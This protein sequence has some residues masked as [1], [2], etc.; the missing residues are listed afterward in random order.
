MQLVLER[1]QIEKLRKTY[2]YTNG[3]D[4]QLAQVVL[5]VAE[6]WS[7]SKIAIALKLDPETISAYLREYSNPKKPILRKRLTKYRLTSD[8][9]AELV[10]HIE[11]NPA[12]S[13]RK[14]ID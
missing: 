7:Q 4:R 5:L 14:I 6:G 3:K 2:K 8:Q 1:H 10:A 9:E 12:T 11:R 13:V